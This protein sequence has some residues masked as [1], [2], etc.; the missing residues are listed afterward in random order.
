MTRLK[1]GKFLCLGRECHSVYEPRE[2]IDQKA[3]G[4]FEFE[5]LRIG[6]ERLQQFRDRVG[7]ERFIDIHHNAF[8][9]DPLGEVER[10]YSWLGAR[11]TPEA[12][13][14][15]SAWSERHRSG[16]RG[17]HRYEAV[18]FGLSPAAISEALRAY[19]SRNGIT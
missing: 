11:L 12:S 1:N 3:L 9:T 15:M 2:V 4:Q 6:I 18:D 13:A 5:H 7:N 14:A 10:I 16:S 17:E 19:I 8:N